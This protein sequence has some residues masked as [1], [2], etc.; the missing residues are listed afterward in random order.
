MKD[1]IFNRKWT[2]IIFENRN[3]AYGAFLLRREYEKN[4]VFGLLGSN[5]ALALIFGFVFASKYFISTDVKTSAK[6][7]VY[8]F[9]EV[10]ILPKSKIVIP[11]PTQTVQKQ[12]VNSKRFVETVVVPDE[13]VQQEMNTIDELKNATISTQNQIGDENLVQN[14]VISNAA[15]TIENIETGKEQIVEYAEVMPSFPDEYGSFKSYINTRLKY[16]KKALDN[17]IG[18]RVLV[19]FIVN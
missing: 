14:A 19:Q 4:L 18:G 8:T 15:E 5:S 12:K 13:Q 3:Q 2:S 9:T 17:G 6:D 7:I 1:F 16:P 11:P 10:E